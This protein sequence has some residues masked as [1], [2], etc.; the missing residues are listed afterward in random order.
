M[1][2][3]L[4]SIYGQKA[5]FDQLLSAKKKGRL[6]HALL[7]AGP[8]GIGKKKSAWAFAQILL[9]KNSN[10]AC[11]KCSSCLKVENQ[12]SENILFIEPESLNI[13]VES[14]RYILDFLS[15]QSES[16]ARVIMIDSA[17]QMNRQA[18]NSLLKILE[19]P[20]E[21]VYFILISSNLSGL[22]STILSRVQVLRFLPLKKEHVALVMKEKMASDPSQAAQPS[23]WLIHVCQGR[24]DLLEK[25]QENQATRDQA[26]MLLRNSLL[27][28]ELVSLKELND[29]VKNRSQALFVCLCW[30]QIIRDAR[31][32]Q[33]QS[34]H[35]VHADHKDLIAFLKNLPH[36]FL[37]QIFMEVIQLE[38]SVKSYANSP[39]AFDNLLVKMRAQIKEVLR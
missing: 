16:P 12:K 36:E 31:K 28:Q 15:L 6:A 23:D 5:G 20:P 18:S 29:L 8:S 38:N 19:E 32:D 37:D 35:L 39:L 21:N 17:H 9:C 26:F 34:S 13:K 11:G 14:I 30:E 7:F 33:L 24:L 1:A 2:Q 3:L 4:K 27:K 22:T 25:W 10:L